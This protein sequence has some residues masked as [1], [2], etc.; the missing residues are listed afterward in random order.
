MEGWGSCGSHLGRSRLPGIA[1]LRFAAG[2][3]KTAPSGAQASSREISSSVTQYSDIFRCVIA[4]LITNILLLRPVISLQLTDL[5]LAS[6]KGAKSKLSTFWWVRRGGGE[7]IVAKKRCSRL[8]FPG[9]V[10][11]AARCSHN[12]TL[13]EV[14]LLFASTQ[15]YT[16][17]NAILWI[18]TSLQTT[19]I[20]R[21]TRT[22]FH[23]LST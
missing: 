4:N 17:P 7:L 10:P 15:Q 3:D 5:H 9:Y 23:Q 20:M 2:H 19:Q 22:Y 11:A 16:D 8:P 6:S 14:L 13:D 21:G 12:A 18:R 1:S